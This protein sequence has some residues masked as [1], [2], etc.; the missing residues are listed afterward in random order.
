MGHLERAKRVMG[1]VKKMKDASIQVR[2]GEP[3]YSDLPKIPYDWSYS[4][5]GDVKEIIP[6]DVPEPLGKPVVHT[7]YIAANLYHDKTTGRAVT[8]VLHIVNQT[9]FDW[10]TKRQATV[11]TATYGS[12]FVTARTATKQIMDLRLTLRYLGVP[13]REVSYLFGDN[14]AVVDSLTIPHSKIHKQHMALS[15]HRV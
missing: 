13:L 5:Y 2:T 8:G 11:E 4:V 15:F 10:F 7:T 3:D 14:K 1:Y 9:P 12:E 6:D